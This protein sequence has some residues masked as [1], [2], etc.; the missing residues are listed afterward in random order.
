[1]R[2]S[3]LPA[4][5]AI[6][7]STLGLTAQEKT[8]SPTRS[9]EEIYQLFCAACH[10]MNLE[11]G[12]A[13]SLIKEHWLFGSRRYMMRDHVNFGIPTVGM[14][15]FGAALNRQEVDNV[16][17]YVL[18]KQGTQPSR[19]PKVGR[20][21]PETIETELNTLKAEVLVSEGLVTPTSIEFV[22]DRR[23][24]VTERPGALRWL[25]D[26]RLDP[27]PI[28]GLPST[29]FFQDAGML[30][31]ALHPNY[32]DNGWIYIA[33]SHPIGDP[34]NRQTPAML[35]IIRG[36]VEGHKWVDNEVIFSVPE[37]EYFTS[38]VHFGCRLLFDTEGYLYFSTGDKGTP[39]LAQSLFSAQGKIHRLHD[40]GSFPKDNP[41][42][43]HPTIH[44]SIYTYGNRNPQGIDQHP[45]TGEIWATEHGPMG[46]DEL[47]IVR[48]GLNHGWPIATYGTN[49]DG[50]TI[51]EKTEY[52]GVTA[53]IHYWVPSIATCPIAFVDSDRF[54]EWKNNLLLGALKY[55]DVRRLVIEGGKVVKE[56][57]IF[58]GYG[59]VRELKFGPDGA[60]YAL[61]NNPDKIVRL[62]PNVSLQSEKPENLIKRGKL[63]FSD[64]F[65]RSEQD[66]SKEQLGKQWVTNSASRAQ[67]AKQADLK[68]GALVI[69]MAKTANHST[70]IRHDI[71][72]DDG[73]LTFK[74]QIFDKQGLKFD[75]NDPAARDVTWAG[76]IARVVFKPG[77][78]QIQDDMTGVF[79][80]KVR[81]KRQN[82]NLG[83]T[84]KA[85]LAAF[86]KS[87]QSTFKAPV[88]TGQWH[89]ATIV[90]LGP[91][92]EVYLDGKS[93]GS[94]SSP[95]LDH[96]VKQ[97]FALGVSGKVIV[98]DINVWSLN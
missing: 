73:V 74:L 91:K 37:E 29:W 6:A 88:Q 30:D 17:D 44:K 56:E 43:N 51:S 76:H 46:G 50:T 18:S 58:Q 53:P 7:L 82:K 66:E 41:F 10:G 89:D 12:K 14:P 79:D 24:L 64:D 90:F 77:S 25:V 63:V 39:E 35:Q 86:L 27:K 28:E 52:P 96:K 97:N 11:G 2:F 42:Y 71:A 9:G 72:I 38:S 80:L 85:E 22:D 13:Q 16:L 20:K 5:V 75:F 92:V 4:F 95:G 84:E 19:D 26:G 49:H 31:I 33:N 8:D 61:L 59:R 78:I 15:S 57:S 45:E 48:A 3:Y 54:P 60:L 67:G 93:I 68:D 55:Q 1:M 83:E 81:E 94:F 36:R 40:D 47:N 23:A 65:N 87:K 69:A 21:I 62:T 70:S 34:K 98:D 32:N